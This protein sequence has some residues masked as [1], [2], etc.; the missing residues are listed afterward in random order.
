[1]TYFETLLVYTLLSLHHL[2]MVCTV[3]EYVMSKVP[4]LKL[5]SLL[6]VFELQ[7]TS[8]PESAQLEKGRYSFSSEWSSK[9]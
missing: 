1:V 5:Y 6:W 7:L 3:Y 8:K 4:T 9:V 2:Y